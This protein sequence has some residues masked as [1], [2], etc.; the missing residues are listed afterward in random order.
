MNS[1]YS[2]NYINK[3]FFDKI[4]KKNINK[5]NQIVFCLWAFSIFFS[6]FNF[7]FY[8]FIFISLINILI[9]KTYRYRINLKQKSPY[10]YLIAFILVTLISMI[11]TEDKHYGVKQLEKILPLFLISFIGLFS[12]NLFFDFKKALKYN[13][14]GLI[15]LVIISSAYTFYFYHFKYYLGIAQ[16]KGFTQINFFSFFE[17]R[18]YVGLSIL[19]ITPYVFNSIYYS[20]SKLNKVSNIFL[21]FFLF[22]LNY[23]SGARILIFLN[24]I[25]LFFLLLA[26]LKQY[27]NKYF[28]ILGIILAGLFIYL[29]ISFHP[30]TK[31]TV[32]LFKNNISIEKLD[33][34][35]VI[36]E[37]AIDIISENFFV[38]VGLGDANNEL[39]KSYK[40]N[41]NFYQLS[42]KFNAHNQYLQILLQSGIVGLLFFYFL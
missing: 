36:W 42:N 16:V 3:F 17:H 7:V 18:L 27:F 19:M 34:R 23:S 9:N 26:N 30:R 33:D 39:T 1:V 14:Y 4:T 12:G 28:V 38:G 8:I 22:Y 41:N 2:H 15:T 24:I 35:V 25:I 40:I 37:N 13:Y 10:F 31:L 20:K 21:L 5:L 11:Y 6:I 32:E 29:M